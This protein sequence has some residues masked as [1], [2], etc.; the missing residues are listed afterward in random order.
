[1][2]LDAELTLERAI[3]VARQSEV[4]KKQAAV[5]HGYNEGKVDRV[6][7]AHTP[8][9]PQE[10]QKTPAMQAEEPPEVDR[11]KAVYVPWL[12]ATHYREVPC[13][14]FDMQQV[15][16]KTTFCSRL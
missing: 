9:V 2:Q 5:L 11:S 15:P 6:S 3:T 10:K 1:M 12:L 8:T 4:I 13:T 14:K 7:Q 16:S